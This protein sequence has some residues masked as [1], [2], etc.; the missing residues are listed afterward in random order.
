MLQ[1]QWAIPIKLYIG[2]SYDSTSNE[3]DSDAPLTIGARGNVLTLED[4]TNIIAQGPF[5]ADQ[6]VDVTGLS[7]FNNTTTSTAY[8]NGS[9]VFHGG[10]GMHENLNVFGQFTVSE[11]YGNTGVT[12]ETS[13]DISTDGNVQIDGTLDVEDNAT[14]GATNA[15]TVTFVSEIA[16]HFIPDVHENI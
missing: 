11:G 16:S 14:F 13:G 4:S 3:I 9:V 12:I 5:L 8:N 10:V 15:N 1:L 7:N 2:H 6:T